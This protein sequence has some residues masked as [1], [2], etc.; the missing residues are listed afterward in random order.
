MLITSNIQLIIWSDRGVYSIVG[1]YEDLNDH[2]AI[3]KDI[4]FQKLINRSSKLSSS[5]T[6]SRFKNNITKEEL[7]S[8]LESMVDHF[9]LKIEERTKKIRTNSRA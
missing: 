7:V 3:R 1:G 2:D 9:V 8:I 4:H 5:S 6:L